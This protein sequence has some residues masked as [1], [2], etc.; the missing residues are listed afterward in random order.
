MNT[1]MLIILGVL[2]IVM[3]IFSNT[4]KKK[5]QK[6]EEVKRSSL[7]KGV[8]ISTYSGIIGRVEDITEK[9]IKINTGNS[10]LIILKEAFLKIVDEDVKLFTSNSNENTTASKS[11]IKIETFTPNTKS[12]REEYGF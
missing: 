11:N 3:F 12:K 2:M 7:T 9:H 6:A 10:S 1:P 5:M 4:Q 8:M